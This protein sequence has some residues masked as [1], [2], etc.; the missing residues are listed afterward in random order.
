MNPNQGKDTTPPRP[1]AVPV[2]LAG[3]P[4][5]LRTLKRFIVWGNTCVTDEAGAF[6]KYDKP[7][8][9]PRRPTEHASSTNAKTWGTLAEANTALAQYPELLDGIGI[10]LGPDHGPPVIDDGII[11]GD[12]DDCRDCVTGAIDPA[13]LAIV[14]A[15]PTYW[16]VS[17]SGEGLRMIGR[18]ALPVSGINRPWTWTNGVIGRMEWYRSGKYLTLTGHRLEDC[19]ETIE[20]VAEAVAGYVA[21]LPT[22]RRRAARGAHSPAIARG[23]V[24]R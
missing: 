11:V 14:A 8:R 6:L 5:E 2:R 19:P 20:P 16:E 10:A 1:V 17:P 24:R 4:H 15:C 18:G 22:G 12:L 13:A 23:G 7:P 9:Q 3:I 21:Q